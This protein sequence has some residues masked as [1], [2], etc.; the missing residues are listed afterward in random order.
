MLLNKKVHP[1]DYTQA[2]EAKISA[3]K[4]R[5]YAVWAVLNISFV[6]TLIWCDFS[7]ELVSIISAITLCVS[8]WVIARYFKENNDD[9][10]IYFKNY[11][12]DRWIIDT[13]EIQV[14]KYR[15]YLDSMAT[16][17]I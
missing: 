6:V 2:I 15:N 10:K 4:L 8:H 11:F 14:I 3:M 1:P 16:R 12:E 5:Y 9:F 13:I 7:V 17:K